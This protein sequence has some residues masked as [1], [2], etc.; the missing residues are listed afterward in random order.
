MNNE[1]TY[2][3]TFDHLTKEEFE[4]FN[5]AVDIATMLMKKPVHPYRVFVKM[6][7]EY[8]LRRRQSKGLD[9]SLDIDA[10]NILIENVPLDIA[11][12]FY[13]RAREDGKN[14]TLVFCDLMED[15][16]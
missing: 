10:I 15:E 1:K 13:D 3:L 9:K 12:R 7:N 5:Q 16:K 14:S 4:R 11:L 2:S 6:L 8:C